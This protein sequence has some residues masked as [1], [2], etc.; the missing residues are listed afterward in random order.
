MQRNKQKQKQKNKQKLSRRSQRH[1][2]LGAQGETEGSCKVNLVA[3]VEK[4]SSS[5][6]ST[7]P[8]FSPTQSPW[9]FWED[10]DF[11]GNGGEGHFVTHKTWSA[12]C[13]G[14]HYQRMNL[15]F[16]IKLFQ[17]LRKKNNQNG[18]L[19]QPVTASQEVTVLGGEIH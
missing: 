6:G 9:G 8:Q 7:S 14:K 18:D 17:G 3:L 10:G 19:G 13:V 2:A 4:V 1:V 5:S 12:V 11:F 15:L 16:K